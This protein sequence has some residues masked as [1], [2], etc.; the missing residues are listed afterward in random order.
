M[1][2]LQAALQTA[3]NNRTAHYRLAQL[4]SKSGEQ[5]KAA[6]E[7]EIARR[8]AALENHSTPLTR[9]QDLDR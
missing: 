7:F 8:L 5:A 9:H 3:P 6:Q 2:R 1:K 4:Y